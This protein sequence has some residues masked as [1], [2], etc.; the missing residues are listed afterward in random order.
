MLKSFEKIA[1]LATLTACAQG[2]NLTADPREDAGTEVSD[3][4]TPDSGA[5]VDCNN[6]LVDSTPLLDSLIQAAAKGDLSCA[7]VEE[8]AQLVLCLL[9]REYQPGPLSRT[10]NPTTLECRSLYQSGLTCEDNDERLQCGKGMGGGGVSVGIYKQS[11]GSPNRLCI[12]ET[13]RALCF[14]PDGDDAMIISVRGENGNELVDAEISCSPA[15]QSFAPLTQV[16][17]RLACGQQ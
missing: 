4:A 10:I 1:F 8:T 17:V 9:E 11:D 2:P 12:S 6:T 13:V 3:A 14:T 7:Q 15:P 5:P 16:L